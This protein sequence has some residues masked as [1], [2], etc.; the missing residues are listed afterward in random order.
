S[1]VDDSDEA[2]VIQHNWHELRLFMW[3][4]VGIVRTDKRLE[5]AL[6]R[7]QLLQQEIDEYYSNFKVGNNLLELRNLVQVA[8]IIIKSA[9]K[10][11]ESRGLHYNLDYPEQLDNPKP[12][13]LSPDKDS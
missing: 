3:D 13:I 1:Q 7:V 2:V 8:E 9:M 12:T 5:R 4:Y 6:R 10:R 11:K